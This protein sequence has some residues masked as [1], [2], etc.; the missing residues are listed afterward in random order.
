MT[1]IQSPQFTRKCIYCG[2]SKVTKEHIISKWINKAFPSKKE[3]HYLDPW[4]KDRE[5]AN[6]YIFK[7]TKTKQ[8]HL[9]TLKIEYVCSQCNNGWMSEIVNNSKQLIINLIKDKNQEFSIEQLAFLSSW[10][11]LSALNFQYW[12]TRHFEKNRELVFL[13]DDRTFMLNNNRPSDYWQIWTGRSAQEEFKRA[14]T[15]APIT[16]RHRGS[17]LTTPNSYDFFM[18]I[19]KVIF[20]A[21]FN[22]SGGPY[23]PRFEKLEKKFTKIWPRSR[24]SLIKDEILSDDESNLLFDIIQSKSTPEIIPINGLSQIINSHLG[25]IGLKL[26]D[27]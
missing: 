17:N 13:N 25:F 26:N 21:R 6:R 1:D 22:N 27:F 14:I 23:L 19:E 9:G 24:N 7:P 16:I 18:A 2:N 12:Q 11:V 5:N 10:I 15:G 20:I 8:G 3:F 4:K